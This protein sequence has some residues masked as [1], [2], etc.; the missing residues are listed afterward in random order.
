MG[1]AATGNSAIS[2]YISRLSLLICVKSFFLTPQ[3]P[4]QS[5]KQN[6]KT[7]SLGSE[8]TAGSSQY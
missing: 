5:Q 7:F 8:L 3:L 2:V 4:G 6:K 1:I